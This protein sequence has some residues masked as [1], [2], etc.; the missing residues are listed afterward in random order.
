M[1]NVNPWNLLFVVIN[2]LVLLGL[3]KKFLYQPVLNVIEKRQEMIESQFAQ[4][5][6]AN[7]E[8][9]KL[10]LQ[11]ESCLADAKTEYAGIVKDAKVQAGEEYDKILADAEKK[12]KDLI[13]EAK[14]I[15]QKEKEK[16]LKEADAQIAKLAVEAAS[17]IV[18]KASDEKQNYAI[19][20]E[21]LKEAGEKK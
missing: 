18:A 2:L 12:A 15:G 5:A 9:K 11:Y 20:E 3:M 13:E 8:A 17:K 21:F 4:A 6:A 16:V 19:Y 1:L 14:G 7:E 10:K